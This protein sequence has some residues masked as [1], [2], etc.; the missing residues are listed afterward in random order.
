VLQRGDII[1]GKFVVVGLVGE[2][3]MGAVYEGQNL[4]LH[5]R[6]AIKVM[7]GAMAKDRDMVRRFEREAQA[8]AKIDSRHVAE[9]Y[10]LGDLPDGDRYMIMEFLEGETLGARLKAR[11][12]LTPQE[13]AGIAIQVLD[14]LAAIHEADIV[15][16]DLKPAN[17][18]LTRDTVKI[19]DFGIC[20]VV[21]GANKARGELSTAVGHLLGT[22][23]YMC[24]EMIEHG[25]GELD[26]RADIYSVGIVLYRAVSGRVPFKSN[27]LLDLLRQMREGRASPIRELVPDLDPRF[28]RIVDKAIE[29]DPKARFQT[30]GELRDALKRWQSN[31]AKI[32]ELLSDFLGPEAI[33]VDW[34]VD[35]A[36]Q[37]RPAPVR[38][39]RKKGKTG[40]ASSPSIPDL[41]DEAITLPRIPAPTRRK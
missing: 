12:R 38:H 30:A 23:A 5:R 29:W 13:I 7:H 24:P 40:R 3:G 16:R 33:A 37:A 21:R 35:H 18:F 11:Q 26:G 32:D 19:L 28:A 36:P 41:D 34:D 4:R 22:L 31:V 1:D 2:G 39:P 17:I 25:S 14:G 8:A 6:V 20:K 27:N 15:H 9:V 10:D